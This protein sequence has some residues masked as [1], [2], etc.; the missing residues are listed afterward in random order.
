MTPFRRRL[1]QQV[2]PIVVLVHRL[3]RAVP[4]LVVAALLLGGLLLQGV[5]GAGLLLVLVALLSVLLFLSWPTLDPR[6]RA[7]RLGVLA[8]L[9]VRTLSFL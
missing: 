3:P 4:F 1:E 9:A 7:L 2:G 8:L 5:A 6:S